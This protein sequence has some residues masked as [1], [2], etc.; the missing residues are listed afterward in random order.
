MKVKLSFPLVSKGPSPPKDTRNEETETKV[1]RR[2]EL[3]MSSKE[4][5]KVM[6]VEYGWTG[7]IPNDKVH[8]TYTV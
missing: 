4:W 3:Y 1:S 6:T 8:N 5:L 7:N 2:S